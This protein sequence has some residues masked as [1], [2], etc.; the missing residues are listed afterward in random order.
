MFLK[1]S[2]KAY[3]EANREKDKGNVNRPHDR[4]GHSSLSLSPND[5]DAVYLVHQIIVLHAHGTSYSDIGT[6]LMDNYGLE[7]ATVVIR[8][9]TDKVLSLIKKCRSQLLRR[10]Y[11]TLHRL[12]D[13]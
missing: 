3:I 1:A 12:S 5:T 13:M 2:R 7:V 6:H 9:A 10:V 4:N 11:P 8:R